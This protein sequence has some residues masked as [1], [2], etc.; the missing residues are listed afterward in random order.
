MCIN[1]KFINNYLEIKKYC[2]IKSTVY[3][4]YQ[5]ILI[6]EVLKCKILK[7]IK[8]FHLNICQGTEQS[9]SLGA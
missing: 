9:A 1:L 3:I 5:I 2:H 7:T 4:Y 6:S 8:C